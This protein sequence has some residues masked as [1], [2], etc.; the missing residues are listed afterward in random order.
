VLGGL[1]TTAGVEQSA[2][3]GFAGEAALR[4]RVDPTRRSG[5]VG[6]EANFTATTR[7]TGE[8]PATEVEVCVKAPNKVKVVGDEC[9]SADS[10]A[11]GDAMKSKFT[12]KPRRSARG[13][14]VEIAF[15]AKAAGLPKEKAD[16]T[17]KVRR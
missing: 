13:D 5:K 7:N 17:L 4:L 10:L 12:V 14:K 3:C 16:A 9:E 2:T 6:K 11:A 15:T 8:S 1:E